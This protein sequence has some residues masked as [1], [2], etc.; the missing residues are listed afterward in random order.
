V[1]GEINPDGAGAEMA[2]AEGQAHR[3]G[4]GV[5]SEA[6][7]GVAFGAIDEA[8]IADDFSAAYIF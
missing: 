6:I 4:F 1:L 8:A 7:M 3:A 2:Y 5:V